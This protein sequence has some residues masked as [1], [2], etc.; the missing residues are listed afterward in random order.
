MIP[1]CSLSA[2]LRPEF[3]RP[4]LARA[5]SI[6]SVFST[7]V[8]PRYPS[9]PQ[10]K[11]WEIFRTNPGGLYSHSKQ[12][13]MRCFQS[14]NM[15][16]ELAMWC[17]QCC[18]PVILNHIWGTLGPLLAHL[19][20]LPHPSALAHANSLVWFSFYFV[21]AFLSYS[22]NHT[23]GSERKDPDLQLN[24]TTVTSFPGPFD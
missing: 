12:C 13:Y 3:S 23:R 5:Y 4:A 22:P 10:Y 16:R 19:Y 21:N 8:P 11:P 7:A 15:Q 2:L 18:C 24:S 20:L 1:H 6:F 14:G 9:S 17:S